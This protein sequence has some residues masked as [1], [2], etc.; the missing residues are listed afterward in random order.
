METFQ[1]ILVP[2]DFEPADDEAIEQGRAVKAGEHFVE[3]SPASMRALSHAAAIARGSGG[4]LVLV[5][6]TP[7]MHS[8]AM[9]TGPV[10]LPAGIIE[11]I[12]SKARSTSLSALQH[13]TS[14][15]CSGLEVEHAVGPPTGREDGQGRPVGGRDAERT[16]HG[17][18][19][20]LRTVGADEDPSIPRAVGRGG[21]RLGVAA[22]E[23][24]R[25]SDTLRFIV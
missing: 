14:T 16:V 5:H 13:V 20:R 25:H 4:K 8:T 11:E 6:V 10:S 3:F 7:P 1:T 2:I 15:V 19:R 17:T 9:Y 12:E 22:V 21:D 24:S 18:G 23:G